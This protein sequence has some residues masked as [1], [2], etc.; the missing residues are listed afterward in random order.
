MLIFNYIHKKLYYMY[1]IRFQTE[2]TIDIK[3][4]P[5]TA[6]YNTKIINSMVKPEMINSLIISKLQWRS[7]ERVLKVRTPPPKCLPLLNYFNKVLQM[8]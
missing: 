4:K 7:Q 5:T 3:F 1:Y 8:F 2:Y 6:Y